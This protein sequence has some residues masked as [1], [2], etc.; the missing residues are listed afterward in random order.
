MDEKELEKTL[1]DV[2][3]FV[4]RVGRSGYLKGHHENETANT[5]YEAYLKPLIRKVTTTHRGWK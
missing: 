2:A 1:R 5:I 3:L 4:T